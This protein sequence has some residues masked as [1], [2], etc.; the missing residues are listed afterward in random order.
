MQNYFRTQKIEI[1]NR[2]IG[3][4]KPS[5]KAASRKMET[6]QDNF[7]QRSSSHKIRMSKN[8][9]VKAQGLQGY[10]TTVDDLVEKY[11]YKRR[12]QP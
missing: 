8:M 2:S 5:G 7:M 11:N 10:D 4:F 1:Q 6:C 9:F 12:K 3:S